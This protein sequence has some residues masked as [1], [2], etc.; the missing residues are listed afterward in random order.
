MET[1]GEL[2]ETKEAVERDI[3]GV[4]GLQLPWAGDFGHSGGM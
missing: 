4:D 3:S 1:E 2:K